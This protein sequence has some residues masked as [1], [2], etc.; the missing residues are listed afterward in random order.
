M[1]IKGK[2]IEKFINLVVAHWVI[3]KGGNR[4][5]KTQIHLKNTATRFSLIIKLDNRN[6]LCENLTITK[7]DNIQH[8][9]N[10]KL[11]KSHILCCENEIKT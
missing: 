4:T 5:E 8:I 6:I 11:I 7:A 9:K 10:F 1:R 3:V 2:E